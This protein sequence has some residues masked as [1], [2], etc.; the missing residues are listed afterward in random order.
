[1]VVGGGGGVESKFSAQ[2]S[3]KLNKNGLA[4]CQEYIADIEFVVG[5]GG[6]GGWW[7]WWCPNPF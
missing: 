5:G 4:F 6:G 2:L 1:M 3:L 7:L